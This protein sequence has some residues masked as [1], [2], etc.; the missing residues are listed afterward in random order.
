MDADIGHALNPVLHVLA[1]VFLIPEGF[2]VE[3]ILLDVLHAGFH[4]ALALRIVGFAGMDPE[5]RRGG[6]IMESLVEDQFPVMLV[7]HHQ[8]GLIV[9]ALLGPATEV[10]QGFVMKLD[11]RLGIQRVEGQAHIL[12]SR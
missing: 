6:I 4:L 10:P 8:L 9:N 1:H 11:K 2:T 5:P 7:D 3:S 12:R